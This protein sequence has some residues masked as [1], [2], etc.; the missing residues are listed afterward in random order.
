MNCSRRACFAGGCGLRC[1]CENNTSITLECVSFL[2][3]L[4]RACLGRTV[5]FP[6]KP[7]ALL[8][9]KRQRVFRRWQAADAQVHAACAA[10]GRRADR[11][12]GA[13]RGRGS[14]PDGLH[15][16]CGVRGLGAKN[17]SLFTS[18]PILY[19]K[20]NPFTKTGSGQT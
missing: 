13:R 7:C 15:W 3:S 2:C 6:Q 18:K 17:A 12:G 16:R 19:T 5:V 14:Q 9:Q 10:S 4:S 1:R 11:F 20:H 8:Y